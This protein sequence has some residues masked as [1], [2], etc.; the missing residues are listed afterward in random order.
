M[1]IGTPTIKVLRTKEYGAEVNIVGN[2]FDEAFEA[3][4]DAVAKN[5]GTL[6]IRMRILLVLP[7]SHIFSFN[8]SELLSIFQFIRSTIV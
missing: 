1:P 4:M 5:N 2:S 3:C 7:P 8:L 6:G